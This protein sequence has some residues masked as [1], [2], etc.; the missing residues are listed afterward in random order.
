[1]TLVIYHSFH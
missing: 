1:M